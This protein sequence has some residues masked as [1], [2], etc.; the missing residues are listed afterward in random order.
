MKK[1]LYKFLAVL[2]LG[3]LVVF[4]SACNGG[5]ASGD[6]NLRASNQ[7]YLDSLGRIPVGAK[8]ASILRIHNESSEQFKLLASNITSLTDKTGKELALT[9]DSDNCRTVAAGQSCQIQADLSNLE[10]GSYLLQTILQGKDGNKLSASQLIEIVAKDT[11]TNTGIELSGYSGAK[12]IAHNGNYH[13]N[14]PV[15]LHNNYE[16]IITSQGK[17]KCNYGFESGALCNWLI[18]GINSEENKLYQLTIKGTSKQNH[19][20]ATTTY[21]LTVTNNIQA[22][23]L[24]SQIADIEINTAVENNEQR[25]VVFNSGNYVATAIKVGISKGLKIVDN[26]CNE[27]LYPNQECSFVVQVPNNLNGNGIVEV[28]YISDATE[29]TNTISAEFLFALP[30]SAGVI[31]L[32]RSSGDIDSPIFTMESRVITVDVVNTG[33]KPI[34]NIRF[35]ALSGVVVAASGV[36]SCELNGQESLAVGASCL[37]SVRIMPEGE[38]ANMTITASGSYHDG[39]INR[40]YSTIGT[41]TVPVTVWHYKPITFKSESRPYDAV[42]FT[43][44][45]TYPVQSR[46]ITVTNPNS[47]TVTM[48]NPRLSA[49]FNGISINATDCTDNVI[50]AGGTCEIRITD[51]PTTAMTN[52]KE[53]RKL[54]ITAT[55]K[56]TPEKILI[57]DISIPIRIIKGKV[58]WVSESALQGNFRALYSDINDICTHDK[59]NPVWKGAPAKAVIFG[60]TT[61]NFEVGLPY[62][63]WNYKTEFPSRPSN[64][65]YYHIPGSPKSPIFPES[66][67]V[68][69]GATLWNW[70]GNSDV[71]NDP[72]HTED[73]I[74]TADTLVNKIRVDGTRPTPT[75]SYQPWVNGRH[76]ICSRKNGEID[77]HSGVESSFKYKQDNT[78]SLWNGCPGP[79][80]NVTIG[81]NRSCEEMLMGGGWA[82][83]VLYIGNN[84]HPSTGSVVA[85]PENNSNSY[86][87][88][89]N[90][91]GAPGYT[92]LYNH[93]ITPP[94]TIP[95]GA[96]WITFTW[97]VSWVSTFPGYNMAYDV[98]YPGSRDLLD[99]AISDDPTYKLF[100]GSKF[101]YLSIP[102][103]SRTLAAGKAYSYWERNGGS[104][105]KYGAGAGDIL[106][107]TA[108]AGYY[109]TIFEAGGRGSLNFDSTKYSPTGGV[110][111][112]TPGT[113]W[114]WAGCD[115]YRHFI[116]V[117]E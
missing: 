95:P 62:I 88:P 63:N 67:Y 89:V 41:Y 65:D 96:Y 12:V 3:A 19:K 37:V 39:N 46:T 66:T 51:T 109:I 21:Q 35:E 106:S 99:D 105:S 31:E 97:G 8:G 69:N 72:G 27:R 110:P 44:V 15:V 117:Q 64:A 30:N 23:L 70:D 52:F 83:P 9:I 108:F 2:V 68:T 73:F 50:D 4:L 79:T 103:P 34:S 17:L 5:G 80:G 7:V 20:S 86:T 91:A 33:T 113:P 85:I 56:D 78:T 81:G 74:W 116:C 24:L 10:V 76:G 32:S 38:E 100:R 77:G 29:N 43:H 90:P 42:I 6:N 1:E 114:G 111:K 112:E 11:S 40:T 53:D 58:A 22:N 104:Y 71:G 36:D 28:S 98:R 92:Q 59:R 93:A 48:S 16:S 25:V 55:N 26:E 115:T 84:A 54:I 94:M 18:D 87:N 101:D 49:V 82:W 13:V 14:L 57:Q 61:N 102:A 45:S 75:R 107:L 60:A 47:F